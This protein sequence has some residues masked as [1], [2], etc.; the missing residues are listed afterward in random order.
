MEFFFAC[1]VGRYVQTVY[2][3][4]HKFSSTTFEIRNMDPT[5]ILLC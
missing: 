1:E 5:H 3:Q 4:Q 2:K